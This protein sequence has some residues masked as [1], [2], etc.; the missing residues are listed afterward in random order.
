[1][2]LKLKL[3]SVKPPQAGELA[4]ENGVARGPIE[5]VGS[6]T[7]A[8]ADADSK[9]RKLEAEED[10]HAPPSKKHSSAGALENVVMS[11]GTSAVAPPVQ[12]ITSFKFTIKR[13]DAAGTSKL[14]SSPAAIAQNSCYDNSNRLIEDNKQKQLLEKQTKERLK[15]TEKVRH[16]T[17]LASKSRLPCCLECKTYL[18]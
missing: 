9:K 15:Q 18:M 14:A 3:P 1:M 12:R 4:S 2:K 13:P 7:L 5:A 17:C 6:S 10:Y 11:P 16:Y 8:N